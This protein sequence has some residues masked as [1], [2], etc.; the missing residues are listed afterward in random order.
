M[1]LCGIDMI[2]MHDGLLKDARIGII[3]APT[4]VDRYMRPTYE[5]LSEKYKVTALFAPEHGI[6]GDAQAGDH[7]STYV[8]EETGLTVYSLFGENK[9]PSEEMMS[10]VDVLV[11]DMQDVGARYYTFLYA[12]TR[13]MEACAKYNKEMLV[14]D[15]PNPLGGLTVEGVTLDEAFA[16]GVGEYAVPIRYGLTI[17]EFALYIN[18]VKNIGCNLTVVPCE[19]LKRSMMFDETGLPWILPSPN[20]PTPVNSTL[21]YIAT[22]Y[23]EGTNISEGRGTTMPFELV[24]APF[25]DAAELE[26]RLNAYKLEGVHFRRCYFTPTFSKHKGE[27]CAGVQL[28]ITDR[29]LYRPFEAGMYLYKEVVNL[30]GDKLELPYEGKHLVHLYGNEDILSENFDP[31]TACDIGRE[32]SALF[33]AKKKAYH[34]Y[35]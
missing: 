26:R 8:D 2:S 11:F 17:G 29:E 9:H 4:G 33:A 16:S 7:I 35:Y 23:F 13:C 28:H 6:R 10:Q 14:L 3:T 34:I 22:C 31:A 1:V 19:G 24:G 5:I 32:D 12:M 30:A 27:R 20:I 15:R 25:I 18:S 21:N